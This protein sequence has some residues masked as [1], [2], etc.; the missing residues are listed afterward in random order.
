ML[1]KTVGGDFSSNL[2]FVLPEMVKIRQV[3]D[4]GKIGDITEIIN[5][6]FLKPEIETCFFLLR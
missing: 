6:E 4:P 5:K 2:D 3:F 1:G